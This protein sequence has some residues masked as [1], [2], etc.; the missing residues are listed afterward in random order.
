MLYFIKYPVKSYVVEVEPNRLNV[1]GGPT[2]YRPTGRM[3]YRASLLK[4]MCL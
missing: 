4:N 2:K 3:H 1:S